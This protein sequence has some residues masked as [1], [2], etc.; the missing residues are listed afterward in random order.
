MHISR[1]TK[2]ND[3]DHI[4]NVLSLHN[5]KLGDFVG[6]INPIVLEIKDTTDTAV[7]VSYLEMHLEID[8]EGRLRTRLCDKRGDYLVGI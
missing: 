6:R 2:R 5:C 3:P 7:S 8:S 4:T 1:K